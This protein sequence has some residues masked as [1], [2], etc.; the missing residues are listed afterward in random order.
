[1]TTNPSMNRPRFSLGAFAAKRTRKRAAKPGPVREAVA[2]PPTLP[3]V[4]GLAVNQLPVGSS[5]QTLRLF[6]TNTGSSPISCASQPYFNLRFVPYQPLTGSDVGPAGALAS[7]ETVRAF[8]LTQPQ[9]SGLP[10]TVVSNPNATN[11]Y[12]TLSPPK[13]TGGNGDGIYQLLGTGSAATIVFD[14]AGVSAP[15]AGVTVATVS[16]GG[17]ASYAAGGVTLPIVK[18][19]PA[20]N[21]APLILAFSVSPGSIDL[22]AGDASQVTL[23]FTVANAVSVAIPAAN[24]IAQATGES[25]SVTIP[26]DR[27]TDYTLIAINQAGQ[28]VSSSQTVTVS[29]SPYDALPSGTILMWSGDPSELPVGWL[30][31][32]GQTMSDGSPAPNLVDQFVVGAGASYQPGHSA[33]AQSHS[34]PLTAGG[35]KVASNLGHT[36]SVSVY[37]SADPFASNS[38]SFS[39]AGDHTHGITFNAFN[40]GSAGAQLPAMTAVTFLLKRV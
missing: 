37:D 35:Y 20:V 6:I 9:T 10:W 11:P 17:T 29:P 31:C 15:C 8:T 39:E 22:A 36:H 30:L 13:T 23:S 34:H 27:T 19:P 5:A 12:W 18:T 24:F 26:V 3:I 32:N 28:M 25:Q 7:V 4:A 2:Q 14:V 21:P 40:T 1:M 38:A 33:A 16:F